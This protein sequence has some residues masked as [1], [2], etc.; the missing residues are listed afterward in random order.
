[1]V[2]FDRTHFGDSERGCQRYG[3]DHPSVGTVGDVSG[4]PAGASA[5]W[6]GRHKSGARVDDTSALKV[7]LHARLIHVP[8]RTSDVVIVA[9]NLSVLVEWRK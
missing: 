3:Q 8:I 4:N 6:V 5:G 7:H 1:M 2:G 9:C